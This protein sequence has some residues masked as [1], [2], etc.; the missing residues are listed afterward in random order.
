M[1]EEG[2]EQI[3]EQDE[4][5]D[6]IN[7]VTPPNGQL[8]KSM[9]IKVKEKSMKS[10]KELR[11]RER[12]ELKKSMSLILEYQMKKMQQKLNFLNNID[13]LLYLERDEIKDL[14]SQIFSERV[15]LTLSKSDSRKA[16]ASTLMQ[17]ASELMPPPSLMNSASVLPHMDKNGNSLKSLDRP[18]EQNGIENH[19]METQ[20]TK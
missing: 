1:M 20:H 17:N 10:S 13:K 6:E 9:V 11:K 5:I 19:K 4:E 14:Q 7:D 18:I 16:L 2:E 3:E 8:S 12:K 15:S